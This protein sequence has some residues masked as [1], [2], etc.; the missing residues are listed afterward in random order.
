MKRQNGFSLGVSATFLGVATL[1]ALTTG[2]R[3]WGL[4]NDLAAAQRASERSRNQATQ[5]IL[6]GFSLPVNRPLRICNQAGAELKIPALAVSYWGR[7]GRLKQFNSAEQDWHTWTLARGEDKTIR[8]DGADPWDGSTIFYAVEVE[9][10]GGGR[11]L[12]AGT[13]DDLK[14]NACIDIARD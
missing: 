3:W 12:I 4:R 11:S 5:S 13:S 2:S 7:D 6:G 1:A 14:A 9:R 8:F 10:A